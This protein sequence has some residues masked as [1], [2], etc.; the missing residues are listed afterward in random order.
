[1]GEHVYMHLNVGKYRAM[2]GY[3]GKYQTD[4]IPNVTCPACIQADAERVREIRDA[5]PDGSSLRIAASDR[6]ALLL[7]NPCAGKAREA[8]DG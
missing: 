8:R 7:A 2:C 6:L 3:V 5:A 1:M 4:N